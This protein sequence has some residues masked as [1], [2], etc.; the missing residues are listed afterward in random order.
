MKTYQILT[1]LCP[2]GHGVMKHLDADA[3][4]NIG[5]MPD[6]MRQVVECDNPQCAGF[7]KRFTVLM[8][9]LDLTEIAPRDS[10]L[11][12]GGVYSAELELTE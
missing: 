8:P 10:I 6:G 7:G 2:F 11:D 5:W 4:H 1:V 9:E 3:L 12:R